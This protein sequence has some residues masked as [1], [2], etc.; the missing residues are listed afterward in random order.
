M[1]NVPV[2]RPSKLETFMYEAFVVS[3]QS[4]DAQSQYGCVITTKKNR[5]LGTGYN[6][7]PRDCNNL[8]LPNIRP[9]KYPYMIHAE[10]NAIFNCTK[11]PKSVK[12]GG[13]AYVTGHCCYTCLMDLWQV[14]VNVVYQY[15]LRT[16]MVSKE[17][18][19][20]KD[21]FLE[22]IEIKPGM[23]IFTVKPKFEFVKKI[24]EKLKVHS[25]N[26]V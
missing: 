3:M 7:F 15:D 1:K 21:I 16:P 18:D 25:Q 19:E 20:I 10:K 8:V 26:G 9:F 2:K 11:M 23:K 6:S 22:S 5:I 4:C 14:G 17:H 13:T 24:E 12:G